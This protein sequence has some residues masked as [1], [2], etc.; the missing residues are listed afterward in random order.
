MSFR[1]RAVV[2]LTAMIFAACTEAPVGPKRVIAPPNPS[3]V[4]DAAVAC[5]GVTMPVI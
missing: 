1:L 4:M 5:T 3:R 2:L